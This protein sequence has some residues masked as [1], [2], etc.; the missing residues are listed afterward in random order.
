MIGLKAMDADSFGRSRAARALHCTVDARGEQQVEQW[1][2]R[3]LSDAHDRV[4]TEGLP[5]AWLAMIDR[6]LPRD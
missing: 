5:P 1:L 6:K 4:L 2:R 3:S